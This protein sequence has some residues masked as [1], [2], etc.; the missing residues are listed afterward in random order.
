[1]HMLRFNQVVFV[2]IETFGAKTSQECRMTHNNNLFIFFYVS[3]AEVMFQELSKLETALIHLKRVLHSIGKFIIGKLQKVF[4]V[5]P[6]WVKSLFMINKIQVFVHFLE[7]MNINRDIHL[8]QIRK[9]KRSKHH[10]EIKVQIM[11]F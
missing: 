2:M 5:A 4:R 7:A 6:L 11:L 1:M 10:R 8:S 9:A 3:S